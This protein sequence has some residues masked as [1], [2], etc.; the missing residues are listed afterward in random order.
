MRKNYRS[1]AG[2]ALIYF[3]GGVVLLSETAKLLQFP[4]VVQQM[5][6]AGFSGRKL[7]LV[8]TLGFA[9]ALLFLNRRTRSIGLLLLSSFLGGAICLHVQRSEY[10]YLIGPAMLL[11]L[12]W[13]GMLLRHPDVLLSPKG[14]KV[15]GP[16]ARTF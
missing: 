3:A 7:M 4:P 13:I 8:A 16:I 12:A 2:N 5:A 1:I 15:D 10:E 11:G 9:S 14:E 6:H